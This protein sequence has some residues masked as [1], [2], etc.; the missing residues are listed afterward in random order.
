MPAASGCS[1]VAL[2]ERTVGWMLLWC[3]WSASMERGRPPAHKI[4]RALVPHMPQGKCRMRVR[5]KQNRP[6]KSGPG[7]KA[8]VV[9]LGAGVAHLVKGALSGARLYA[10]RVSG[11]GGASA[12]V[13]GSG[14]SAHIRHCT[15][16]LLLLCTTAAAAAALHSRCSCTAAALYSR[17]W[18]QAVAWAR[19][20]PR[21]AWLRA[22]MHGARPPVARSWGSKIW[23]GTNASPFWVVARLAP[24]QVQVEAVGPV[25]DWPT[26]AAAQGVV[27]PEDETAEETAKGVVAV[28]RLQL[29][30]EL[31]WDGT[32]S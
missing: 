10:D 20:A 18:L 7:K 29:W 13:A 11:R 30:D 15:V 23:P 24:A 6:S 5:Y 19:R 31:G 28:L 21:T 9:G 2:N 27:L 16:R 32:G 4:S 12:A 3:W 26:L 1:A 25:G 14:G 17:C 8:L 22:H